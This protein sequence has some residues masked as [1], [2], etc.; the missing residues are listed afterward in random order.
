MYY[1]L[2]R[3]DHGFQFTLGENI[4]TEG[5]ISTGNCDIEGYFCELQDIPEWLGLYDDLEFVCKIEL[6]PDSKVYKQYGKSKTTNKFI[7]TNKTPIQ[8]FLRENNLELVSVKKKVGALRFIKQTPELCLEAVR[9]NGWELQYV[10][11]QTLEICLEAVRNNGYALKFVQEQTPELCLEAVR[12]NGLTLRY[13]QE[14]TQE[15]C[16]EAV[17]KNGWALEFVKEQTPE[18]CLEAVRNNGWALQFV[19]EQ[20][21][22]ICLEA[23]RQSGRALKYVQEQTPETCL[24]AVRNTAEALQFVK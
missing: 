14:Q 23:V 5:F 2:L 20:T 8:D 24:E 11:E 15:I 10:R 3:R 4:L 7:L 12:N 16:L 22:E 13:V 9:T 21:P 1:K 6:C 19:Q 18:I 17:R